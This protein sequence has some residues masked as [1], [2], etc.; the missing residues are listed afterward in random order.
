MTKK[1]KA[2]KPKK[3]NKPRFRLKNGR[4]GSVAQVR[5]ERN[6]SFHAAL[7]AATQDLIDAGFEGTVRDTTPNARVIDLDE[8]FDWDEIADAC[9][10]VVASGR[11]RDVIY[12]LSVCDTNGRWYAVTR[13]W[14]SV[15]IA[16]DE[17]RTR[18]KEM[19]ERY[20]RADSPDD[21]KGYAIV[22][23]EISVYPWR[24]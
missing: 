16:A 19:M 11:F 9:R 17:M 18:I 6:K 7:V 10:E 1:S 13:A 24:R 20:R 4:F 12:N 22:A 8:P 15:E 14:E 21:E 3:S 2:K 5:A 23:I